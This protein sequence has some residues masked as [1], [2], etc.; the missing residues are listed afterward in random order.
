MKMHEGG[1]GPSG[2]APGGGRC[3]LRGGLQKHAKQALLL[4]QSGTAPLDGDGRGAE[5]IWEVSGTICEGL[6]ADCTQGSAEMV[7]LCD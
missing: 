7:Q 1:V 6:R 5:F 3:P 4:D 2:P